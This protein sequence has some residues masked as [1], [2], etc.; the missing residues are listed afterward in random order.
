MLAFRVAV[1]FL[2][3]S[4]CF[5]A[6]ISSVRDLGDGTWHVE[7]SDG[8]RADVPDSTGNGDADAV[9]RWITSGGSVSPADPPAPATIKANA[10]ERLLR[11][12]LRVV[13]IDRQLTL[14]PLHPGLTAARAAALADEAAAWSAYD[15]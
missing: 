5:A 10:L 15:R 6:S 4:L 8:T 1:L 12:S 9:R 11:A 3:P 7:Y 2:L 14:H 13:A